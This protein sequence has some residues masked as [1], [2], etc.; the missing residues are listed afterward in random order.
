MAGYEGYNLLAIDNDIASFYYFSQVNN[1]GPHKVTLMLDV[2]KGDFVRYSGLWCSNAE[3]INYWFPEQ[4]VMEARITTDETDFF[5]SLPPFGGVVAHNVILMLKKQNWNVGLVKG[6]DGYTNVEPLL[7]GM[8]PK[9]E[10]WGAKV[11]KTF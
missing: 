5:N 9:N 2:T 1:N 7:P 6:S 8:I 3:A 10:R 11:L 4:L